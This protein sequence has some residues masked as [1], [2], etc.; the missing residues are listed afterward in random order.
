MQTLTLLQKQK[1][2]KE[3]RR[4]KAKNEIV[5]LHALTEWAKEALNLEKAPN[6]P[7]ISSIIKNVANFAA[8]SVDES[9]VTKRYRLSAVPRLEQALFQ[10]LSS[11]NNGVRAL[12]AEVV[13]FHAANFLNDANALFLKTERSR[14]SFPAAGWRDL[15]NITGSSLGGS[16]GKQ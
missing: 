15:R 2:V 1:T 10:W 13:K 7:S 16:T 11:K 9:A 5:T 8:V 12:I 4:G 14:L 6:Q 3:H